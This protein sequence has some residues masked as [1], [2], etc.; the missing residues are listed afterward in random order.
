MDFI[1]SWPDSEINHD[2]KSNREQIQA[3]QDA[4]RNLL[5]RKNSTEFIPTRT[6]NKIN[7]HSTN[8]NSNKM[9]SQQIQRDYSQK[10][11]C[12][13]C[14]K[15]NIGS[16]SHKTPLTEDRKSCFSCGNKENVALYFQETLKQL[17]TPLSSQNFL[18]SFSS[19]L[20]LISTQED[21]SSWSTDQLNK[22]LRSK[23]H[24]LLEVLKTDYHL[25]IGQLEQINQ[26][27]TYAIEGTPYAG[28]RDKYIQTSAI[29]YPNAGNQVLEIGQWQELQKLR[30]VLTSSRL[31]ELL[32]IS[33]FP[34]LEISEA[35][36]SI[37]HEL[38]HALVYE[39]VC[40]GKAV[41]FSENA[42]ATRQNEQITQ[43]LLELI[44][45]IIL[46]SKYKN[47]QEEFFKAKLQELQSLGGFSCF[48]SLFPQ[49]D[50][51]QFKQK[52]NSKDSSNINQFRQISRESF[53]GYMACLTH[54][55][56]DN[57]PIDL[58]LAAAVA[59][60]VAF[61]IPKSLAAN[62]AD[63]VGETRLASVWRGSLR[64]AGAS[65]WTNLPS[66]VSSKL[67]LGTR[68]TL[69]AIGNYAS[70]LV[71]PILIAYGSAL[72]LVEAHCA[73]VCTFCW[74]YDT[75]YNSSMNIKSSLKGYF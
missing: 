74:W 12:P 50:L 20:S 47:I 43:T 45:M 14:T 68:S 22:K 18:E 41:A 10:S 8:L 17:S 65:M 28:G 73:G 67:R 11:S 71:G 39:T 19:D 57:D 59:A 70:Q 60:L 35:L 5:N 64:T 61:P 52:S 27:M 42:T 3:S 7:L 36:I 69:R 31:E 16:V 21:F 40:A 55:I 56:K 13:H 1:P 58:A 23:I 9:Q 44:F 49:F 63:L 38:L 66:M 75:N 37:M 51:Y 4:R 26:K 53:V 29:L 72:A 24:Q 46:Q 62:L 33:F 48:T 6:S 34:S 2:S 25:Q 32:D 15:N 54:C 30:I